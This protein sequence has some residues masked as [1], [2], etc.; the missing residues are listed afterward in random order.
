MVGKTENGKVVKQDAQVHMVLWTPP[1]DEMGMRFTVIF[2]FDESE[3]IK[4]YEKYLTDIVTPQ[5][6]KNA[7][8]VIQGYTDT[9]GEATY[10]RALSLARATE[11]SKIL[12]SALSK[13]SRTDVKFEV[14]G[15]GENVNL[16]QFD[17]KY[18]EGR[19][20]NRSVIIDIIPKK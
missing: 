2:E 12:K 6:P 19:F 5:I 8:V 13:A 18:P 14:R 3:T 4:L 20:Y 10:N 9:I 17:N 16:A 11:V 7:T 1:E 15:F